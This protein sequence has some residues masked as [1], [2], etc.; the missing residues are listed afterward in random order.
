MKKL[1]ILI[2]MFALGASVC[3]SQKKDDKLA[4]PSITIQ[5][6]GKE[7]SLVVKELAID[8]KIVGT[9]AVTT[10]DM[11]FASTYPRVLEGELNF[12]LADGQTVSRYSLEVNGKMREGVSVEKAQGR[13]AFENTIRQ[14]IDPGLLEMT[15]GNS[16]K[17]RIYPIPANGTKRIIIAYEQYLAG[18]AE[19][20]LYT[21]PLNFKDEIKKF[22]LAATVVSDAA[23]DARSSELK[24]PAFAKNGSGFATLITRTNCPA[25]EQF[26]FTV[27]NSG[28]RT[29]W[30]TQDKDG[31]TYFYIN[32]FPTAET[33][34]R[35]LPKN[36]CIL[37]DV[38]SG[39]EG[40]DAEREAMLLSGLFAGRNAHVEFVPFAIAPDETEIFEV[41][42]GDWSAI[43]SRMESLKYDGGTDFST[44]DFSKYAADEF[45]VFTDGIANFGAKE[46]GECRKPITF[47]NAMQNADHSYMRFVAS[48]TGGNYFNLKSMTDE[49][50]TSALGQSARMFLSA[51][52]SA[53]EIEETYPRIAT[54][55]DGSFTICGII[56]SAKASLKLNFGFNGVAESSETIEI[57]QGENQSDLVRKIWAMKKLAH[58]QMRSEKNKPEIVRL[59]KSMT[60]VTPYTSLIVLD[61]VEDYARYEIEPP[62]ELRAEYTK[63]IA[64]QRNNKVQDSIRHAEDVLN[65]FNMKFN[66]WKKDYTLNK[67]QFAVL[68]KDNKGNSI[69]NCSVE[70][71]N[72]SES[73]KQL[74]SSAGV[75]DFGYISNGIYTIKVKQGGSD[76]FS[77]II[78]ISGKK[79]TT[80]DVVIKKS[81]IIIRLKDNEG[82]AIN[83]ANID[84]HSSL[85]TK[86]VSKGNGEY[87]SVAPCNTEIRVSVDMPNYQ[88]ASSVFR[89]EEGS[90]TFDMVVK[91][92]PDSSSLGQI[93]GKV[94][95]KNGEFASGASVAIS[96]EA[97]KGMKVRKDGSYRIIDIPPGNYE[98][99]SKAVGTK[100]SKKSITI[101]GNEI[102]DLD[103]VLEESKAVGMSVK[104]VD[105]ASGQDNENR[106]AVSVDTSER[107]LVATS[108]EGESFIGYTTGV[109]NEGQYSPDGEE[110]P[111]ESQIRINSLEASN[112]FT[113]GFGLGG[114]NYTDSS[115][116]RTINRDRSMSEVGTV[117]ISEAVDLQLGD[118]PAVWSAAANEEQ[119]PEESAFIPVE[120][121]SVLEPSYDNSSTTRRSDKKAMKKSSRNSIIQNEE[122]R[123]K[124]NIEL[125]SENTK[126][127][128]YTPLEKAKDNDFYSKY[129]ELKPQYGKYPVYFIDASRIASERGMKQ[130]ALRILSNIAEMELEN[131]QLM[132]VLGN[133]LLQIGYAGKAVQTLEDVLKIAEEEPQSYR[134]LA[135]AYAENGDAQRAVE[136]LYSIAKK[137]WHGRF[138]EVELIALNEMN[139]IIAQAKTPVNTDGIDS[140]LIKNM[141]VGLRVVLNWDSDNTDID[142]WVTDPADEKCFYSAPRTKSG[143]RISRDFTGGY[144]PEEYMIRRPLS[145]KYTIQANYFGTRQQ[146]LHGP[147]TIYLDIYTDY[148][149][150]QE[151][152]RTITLPLKTNK[153]IVKVGEI[154]VD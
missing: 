30:L 32:T 78:E 40:R 11:T 102:I 36:I 45:F 138:P 110:R 61:R 53:E 5:E 109:F 21:L 118:R 136:M 58:L 128:Y 42:S 44:I 16:F 84:I 82:R 114:M 77:D 149:T 64:M 116:T 69:A 100:P 33:R 88:Y 72:G 86:P 137:D 56:K 59:G 75:F 8:V 13:V 29:T 83:N 141:P 131:R 14:K 24:A 132:R 99:E 23:P 151:K 147:T 41:A 87:E 18:S 48:A 66:W 117:D 1:V 127:E 62:E 79:K 96:T 46:F 74:Q 145:G 108:R 47:V 12:P 142:L 55:A 126:E 31:K 89:T 148:G 134:D 52:Y 65:M 154:V 94:F 3:F 76:L 7:Y 20:L 98:V 95:L 17:S 152:K 104:L 133:R 9:L 27:P 115:S 54:L 107:E 25:S 49:Q 130:L 92:Y 113:G 43:K 37:Y 15:R 140:R 106:T 22:T 26:S 105:N 153:E 120:S 90:Y 97:R 10:L 121:Q 2:A 143:G 124:V 93:R 51:E 81:N 38:S 139:N 112:T 101:K 68:V 50:I 57:K 63:L 39:T 73:Y 123:R 67:C 35:E 80:Y 146:N 6:N 135:I 129:L 144:G 71:Y 34:P 122:P 85:A 4:A 119:I 60:L 150:P 111:N 28:R 70:L 103:F 19:G 91:K 125:A